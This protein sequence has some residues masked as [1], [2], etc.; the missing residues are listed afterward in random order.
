MAK[1]FISLYRLLSRRRWITYTFIILSFALFL[2]FG[3]RIEFEEDISKLLP[4][5]DNNTF[6]SLA[7]KDLR[8]KDK[9]FIQ[10]LPADSTAAVDPETMAALNDEFVTSLLE[11]DTAT[12]YI[13]NVLYRIDDDVTMGMMDYATS[14][15]PTFID[16]TLY[17]RF[18]SI[19]TQENIEHRMQRN[20]ALLFDE[21]RE[22]LAQM[23]AMDPAGLRYA[24]L[25]SDG[26]NPMSGMGGFAMCSGQ[27]FAPDT[28]VALTFLAPNFSSTDSKTGT[29]LVKLIEQQRAIFEQAHPEVEILFHGAPVQSVFNSR[30]IKHDLFI[31][32]GISLLIICI[33]IC[34]CFHGWNTLPLL[35]MPVIYGAAFAM[36]C[37]YW[38]QGGM[39]LM[40]M[41]IGAIVLGVALSYVLHVFTHYKHVTDAEQVLR[42]QAKPVC[43]GCLTTI[44]AFAGLLFTESPLLRDFGLF[45][46]FALVGT[47]LF[48]LI[49]LP[50]FFSRKKNTHSERA[51]KVI[52]KVNSVRYDHP[53]VVIAIVVVCL[54]CFYTQSWVRFDS[55]LTHIGYFDPDVMRS[56]AIY[57]EKNNGGHVSQFYA[58]TATTLDSAILYNNRLIATADSL[59]QAGRIY[60]YSKMSSLL[61]TEAEQQ[62]RIDAW[63][64]YWTDERVS[65]VMASINQASAKQGFEPGTFDMFEA[66][67]SADYEP[68]SLYEAG[69][70]PDGL[71]SNIVEE[72]NG[73]YLI[74]TSMLMDGENKEQLNNCVAGLPHAIVIDPFYYTGDMVRMLNNDFNLVL[75]V[76]MIFVFIVL[77]LSFR[78]LKHALLAFLPMVLSWYIVQG[79]MGIFGLEFNLINIVISTFIFGIGVD[80]S[81]F[82]MDGLIAG[83]DSPLLM[84]HKTAI[85]LSAFVLIVVVASLLFAQH[86]AIKSIGISTLIGMF[87]T[88]LISYSLQ[89]FLFRWLAKLKFGKCKKQ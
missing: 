55:D 36:A 78:N 64:N 5:S 1:F 58:V 87:S 17:A 88:V 4:Q 59:K 24:F 20:H 53:A 3:L 65:R 51:F 41:G 68:G 33:V 16:T 60:G 37:V 73:N 15:L 84:H 66:M 26:S 48:A 79:V 10:M 49:F 12:H 69:I 40:A 22:S 30:Q 74:F 31:S 76:S 23:V 42:E 56:R 75:W 54:V 82:I 61:I 9:I 45:A 6:A 83:K 7:F 21:G 81:I 44:G 80:Y 27:L 89:P 86:P 8:V 28:T 47:T 35:L 70:L 77:I 34:L 39:S 38:I 43:L 85:L 62:A 72:S 57:N 14:Y 19:L 2:G 29:N 71:I 25:K 50:H 67:I 63:R 32:I 52:N 46:S 11:A 18:D 13:D